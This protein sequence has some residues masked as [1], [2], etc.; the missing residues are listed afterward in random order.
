MTLPEAPGAP[1]PDRGAQLERTR[2]AWRRTTLAFAVTAVLAVRG[3]LVG[4]GGPGDA[5]GP[6]GPAG[7]GGT[8]GVVAAVAVLLVVLVWAAFLVVAHRRMRQLAAP[9]PPPATP[10]AVPLVRAALCVAGL[11]ALCVALL[12]G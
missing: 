8:A 7:F 9:A 3:F 4:S 6:G 5:D 10:G 12:P 11:A 1:P 2:L